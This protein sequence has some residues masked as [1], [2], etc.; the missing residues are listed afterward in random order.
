MIQRKRIFLYLISLP[1]WQSKT[2]ITVFSQLRKRL[3]GDS[4]HLHFHYPG[5]FGRLQYIDR[6]AGGGHGNQ[7][8]PFFSI[9]V[10][11]LRKYHPISRIISHGGQQGGMAVQRNSRDTLLQSIRQLF[12]V[13]YRTERFL[14]PL[15]GLD[16]LTAKSVADAA[17]NGDPLA[18]EIYE[19]SG[20]YL[21]K[22]LAMLIDILNPE[23]IVMGSVYERSQ[24]LLWPVVSRIVEQEAL[25][26]SRKGCRIVP[27][28]LG[29]QIGDYAALSVAIQGGSNERRKKN[30]SGIYSGLPADEETTGTGGA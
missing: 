13:F 6:T 20:Y 16:Q 17:R 4:D 8:I 11:L 27:A 5:S 29:N 2:D 25:E 28:K 22:G 24:E 18:K 12:S 26:I 21:G 15:A 23:I 19:I 3:A 30:L 7:Y 1:R 14:L 10:H 9:T